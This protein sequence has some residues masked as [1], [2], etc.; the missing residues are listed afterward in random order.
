QD[1][2]SFFD[3]LNKRQNLVLITKKAKFSAFR[4]FISYVFRKYNHYF[5]LE[6]K[7]DM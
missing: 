5:D 3:Y 4:N 2:M 6:Q 7:V 1:V